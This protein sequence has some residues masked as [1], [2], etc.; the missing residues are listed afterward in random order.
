MQCPSQLASARTRAEG[1]SHTSLVFLHSVGSAEVAC[2]SPLLLG[3]EQ[4][5]NGPIVSF[6]LQLIILL[7]AR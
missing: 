1:E 4:L 7:A 3:P 5:D 6:R 2:F